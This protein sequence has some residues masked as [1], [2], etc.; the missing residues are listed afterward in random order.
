MSSVLEDVTCGASYLRCC[1]PHGFYGTPVETSPPLLSEEESNQTPSIVK[2]SGPETEKPSNDPSSAVQTTTME[3]PTVTHSISSPPL[4]I[5][6]HPSVSHMPTFVVNSQN[7]NTFDHRVVPPPGPIEIHSEERP[8]TT[9]TIPK[10][11]TS[12]TAPTTEESSEINETVETGMV[13]PC[14]GM[15]VE[16]RYAR[17]CGNILSNGYCKKEDEQCCLQS[18][19]DLTKH[20]ITKIITEIELADNPK[21]ELE[22]ET[23]KEMPKAEPTMNTNNNEADLVTL[24]PTPSPL[25]EGTC[26]AP[27][28][29]LLCDDINYDRF[30]P[31]GGSC[32]VNK[33][34]VTTTPLP[35]GPCRGTCI[36]TILSG[37]CNRPSELIFKT[38]DCVPGTICCFTPPEDKTNANNNEKIDKVANEAPMREP[39][40]PMSHFGDM[41]FGGANMPPNKPSLIIPP[42]MPH[43][44][45]PHLVNRPLQ[46][47]PHPRPDIPP[48]PHIVQQRPKP[49]FAKPPP[50]MPPHETPKDEDVKESNSQ[51]PGPPFCPG[52]CIAPMLR[53]TCFGGN[54]IYPKFQ[55]TKPGQICCSSMTDIQ[56]FEANVLANNGVWRPQMNPTNTSIPGTTAVRRKHSLLQ[57][58]Y[59]L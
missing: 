30:C 5:R 2:P 17:Y 53:F 56:H 14:P 8:I 54:A 29:N 19:L 6:P 1:V 58:F 18:D 32:C 3:R 24:A 4:R 38:T 13:Q 31:N 51:M 41:F 39:Q 9:T 16:T 47:I 10:P 27:L 55:C 50:P 28:F 15:C 7:Y 40:P 52:P 20:N 44:V 23:T 12:N 49:D 25:C 45:R 59:L 26:V 48:K 57:I 21:K 43:I 34:P 46:Q 22:E 42:D 37:V 36:P 11:S 33:D 35:I